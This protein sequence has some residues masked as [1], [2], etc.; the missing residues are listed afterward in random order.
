MIFGVA[1]RVN[2]WG[3]RDALR[4]QIQ[5]QALGRRPSP[6]KTRDSCGRRESERRSKQKKAEEKHF[7]WKKAPALIDCNAL[8]MN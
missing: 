5:S 3:D 2:G 7:A 6:C 4:D 8:A 1:T